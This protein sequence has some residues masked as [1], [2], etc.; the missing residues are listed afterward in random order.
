MWGGMGQTFFV[1]CGHCMWIW[2]CVVHNFFL[3]RGPSN[4][5]LG[6]Q[7]PTPGTPSRLPPPRPLTGED[8]HTGMR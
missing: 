6:S 3:V 4:Q 7:V 2:T 1:Y 8:F 5:W